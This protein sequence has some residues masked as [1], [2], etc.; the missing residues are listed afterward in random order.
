MS[1]A[2]LRLS[3]E[4]PGTEKVAEELSMLMEE[5]FGQRPAQI[6]REQ[7]QN[8]ARPTRDMAT[9]LALGSI[10]L[11]VPAAVLAT[12]DLVERMRKKPKADRLVAWAQQQWEK[13]PMTT[14]SIISPDGLA[15]Q[16]HRT[17]GAE[18]LDAASGC[19]EEEK[20]RRNDESPN[21]I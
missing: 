19:L 8:E 3:I 16:L 4:G 21:R 11:S 13:D 1:E 2:Y 20:R 14:I 6:A 17:T 18:L 7:K 15:V 12:L 5:E 10:I 9:I